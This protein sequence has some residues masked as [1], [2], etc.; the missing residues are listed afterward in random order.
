MR[1]YTVRQLDTFLAIARAES[2]SKAAATLHVTQ[3]AVSMQLRQL[4]DA[5]GVAL[6]ESVGRNI[7]LT[8]AGR[9][10]EQFAIAA[11]TQLRQLDD[12]VADLRGLRRGKIDLG[13]VGTAKYF[14]PM[15]LVHF[16]RLY[17]GVDVTL[18]IHNREHI[19][20]LLQ[21][22][23]LDLVIMG[24]VPAVLDCSSSAFATN[25]LGVVSAPGHSLSRRNKAPL[26]ILNDVDFVVRE[27]GSG[28]RVAMERMFKDNA[29]TPRIVMEMPSNESIKQSVMAGMGLTFLSL[30]TVR[31]ELAGGHL[32]L[33]DIQGLPL[34]RHW[35]VAHLR[36]KRL[37]PAAL[38]FKEFLL[39]SAAP[40]IN[41]WA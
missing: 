3:P 40:L 15:L 24:S 33:L 26:D 6:V 20:D 1:R 10:V 34:V 32:A 12:T 37:A 17:P 18:Q 11:I 36:S 2:V 27:K 23:E 25:P 9:E 22:N 16:R 7:R 38:M 8:P 14:V 31:R 4:E 41:T 29:I 28:T 19:L 21:R 13:I 30:R 35:H 5:L 39:T